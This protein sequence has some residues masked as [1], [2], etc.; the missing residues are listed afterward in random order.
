MTM[1]TSLSWRLVSIVVAM[2]AAQG[3]RATVPLTPIS[4]GHL[5]VPVYVDG[6]GPY[7]FILDSGA[8]SSGIYQWFADEAGLKSAGPSITV[9]G[10]TGTVEMKRYRVAS[11]KMEGHE[12]RGVTTYA[13]P[14]RH[15]GAKIAG[16]LGNDFMDGTVTVFDFPCQNVTVHT[17][18]ADAAA[19]AGPG[20]TLVTARRPK[21]D[22]LLSF[23]VSLDGAE[24][25]A[26][27]DTGNRL[28]KINTQFAKAAGLDPHSSAFHPAEAIYGIS[29]T[30]GMVPV[31]GPIGTLSIGALRLEQLQGEV[32]DLKTFTEDF[33][34]SSVMQIGTD[35]VG[36]FRLI[37]E[38]DAN[39]FWLAP[40]TCSR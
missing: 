12:L 34:D 10:M 2:L 22:T 30:Q 28:T 7:P 19:L 25:M 24:G 38:H 3:A 23:P 39:R 29:P 4:D 33:G 17:K 13:L 31:A 14:N 40:S 21:D 8:D 20:S 11:F 35:L 27:L 5:L 16:V 1:A 9:S 37:Y 6:K 15:D 32:L 18:P 26:V 36:R